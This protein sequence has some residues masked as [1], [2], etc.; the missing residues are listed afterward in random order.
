MKIPAPLSE[1]ASEEERAERE[2]LES[3]AV[4]H[5]LPFICDSILERWNIARPIDGPRLLKFLKNTACQPFRLLDLPQELRD[6]VHDHLDFSTPAYHILNA[7]DSYPERPSRLEPDDQVVDR[8]CSSGPRHWNR[9]MM[10]QYNSWAQTRPAANLSSTLL[11]R[12]DRSFHILSLVSREFREISVKRYFGRSTF[13]INLTRCGLYVLED[14]VNEVG[15][16]KLRHVRHMHVRIDWRKDEWDEFD[17]RWDPIHGLKA[18]WEQADHPKHKT[19]TLSWHTSR[20]S[21]LNIQEERNSTGV[22]EFFTADMD[23]LRQ[24]SWGS[25]YISGTSPCGDCDSDDCRHFEDDS[26]VLSEIEKVLRTGEAK[27]SQN[28]TVST[29]MY[30]VINERDAYQV[31]YGRIEAAGCPW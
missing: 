30:G 28:E 11:F 7:Y 22:V 29:N 19:G 31:A 25:Y 27:S 15:K 6:H 16:D 3:W 12:R 23:A 21:R 14:W 24:A 10:R 13:T 17:V 5:T 18:E 1:E 9:P 26:P 4:N 20:I 8:R 2:V